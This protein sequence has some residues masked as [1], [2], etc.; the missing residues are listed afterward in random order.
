ML[1]VCGD[2]RNSEHFP[3]IYQADMHMCAHSIWTYLHAGGCAWSVAFADTEIRKRAIDDLG[4]FTYV[5][6]IRQQKSIGSRIPFAAFVLRDLD[7]AAGVVC[8]SIPAHK[9]CMYVCT[10]TCV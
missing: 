9:I 5:S 2:V 6:A 3:C 7:H 1:C 10:S 8:M 4:A